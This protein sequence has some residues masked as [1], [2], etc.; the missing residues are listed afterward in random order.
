MA[1]SGKSPGI[2]PG[3]S[4][5]DFESNS[6]K[7][8][9]L[10]SELHKHLGT[11]M[12]ERGFK[13][14][15]KSRLT[16]QRVIEGRYHSVWF[17]SDKYGWDAHAGGKF[18][19]NFTVS[20]T[21]DPE[22]PNRRDE[23]LQYFLSDIELA[24]ARQFRNEIVERIPRPSPLY[25]EDLRAG[26]AKIVGSESAKQLIQTVFDEFAQETI[27]Y[28]RNQDFSLRYWEQSDIAGWATFIAAVIPRALEEMESWSLP[29]LALRP[30][31]RTE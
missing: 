20:E 17:Q 25:F 15:R 1:T 11:L 9:E 10:Y 4:Q 3:Q 27:P 13:K 7:A 21:D 14:L 19:V 16:F 24:R 5:Y 26:W 6:M 22:A 2:R 23:R 30:S 29:G 18:F 8:K 31:A 12:A 28:R